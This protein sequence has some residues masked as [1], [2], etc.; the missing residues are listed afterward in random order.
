MC[1]L[2]SVESLVTSVLISVFV[3]TKL[4]LVRPFRALPYCLQTVFIPS[5]VTFFLFLGGVGGGR[6]WVEEY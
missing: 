4:T 3:K 5:Y 2:I 6:L 1:V